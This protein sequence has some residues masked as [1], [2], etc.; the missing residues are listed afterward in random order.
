MR[1]FAG[2][3]DRSYARVRECGSGGITADVAVQSICIRIT[4]L[5]RGGDV[6]SRRRTSIRDVF[7]KPDLWTYLLNKKVHKS[8]QKCTKVT[9]RLFC[10]AKR[11]F[12]PTWRV[13]NNR[14]SASVTSEAFGCRCQVSP[15]AR[16]R[17]YRR[18]VW[19]AAINLIE[20]HSHTLCSF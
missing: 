3:L 12:P 13:Q 20:A 1:Q 4:S 10:E 8:P 15:R 2:V 7:Q 5:R 14:P 11:A 9:K 6:D 17:M 16:P 19:V 18:E